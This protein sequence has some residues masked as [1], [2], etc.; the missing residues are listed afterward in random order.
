MHDADDEREEL[1]AEDVEVAQ[2][3]AG[4]GAGVHGG[5][6]VGADWLVDRHCV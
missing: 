2:E 5:M 4:E 3:Q 6:T 1:A